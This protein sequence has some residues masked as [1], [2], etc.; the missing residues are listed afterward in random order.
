MNIATDE[1]ARNILVD[2]IALSQHLC[3][4]PI[5]GNLAY[6][7][8]ENF[9]GRIIDGYCADADE[10]CLLARRAAHALC[11][12]Q[13]ELNQKE[14][15]LYI[16]DAYRPLRAVRDFAAWYHKP[17]A[18]DYEQQRKTIHYPNLTK[19]DLVAGGYAPDTISRH[20]FGR[21]VDL[22]LIHLTDGSLLE[23]GSCFDF[24]DELSHL[25]MLPEQIGD[26]AYQHRQVLCEAM[27]Q[28]GYASYDYEWWHFDY[29]CSEVDDPMDLVIDSTLKGMN[30]SLV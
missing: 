29:Q 17:I 19:T 15:G 22:T 9:V 1:T 8:K 18:N 4:H 16:F 13:H 7:S 20:N 30:S 27:L 28:H 5:R 24:F 11:H 23:M 6:A 2:V 3:T 14:L 10:I 21:A 25:T 26:L 12:V